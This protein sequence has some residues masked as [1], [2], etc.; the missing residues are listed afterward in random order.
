MKKI[1]LILFLITFLDCKV[2]ETKGFNSLSSITRC[3]NEEVVCYVFEGVKKGGIS[4]KF[5]EDK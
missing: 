1:I 2:L 3:E 5:K 4:C